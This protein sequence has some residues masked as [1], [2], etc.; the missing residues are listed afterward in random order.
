M[1]IKKKTTLLSPTYTHTHP[2]QTMGYLRQNLLDP[3]YAVSDADI[4]ADHPTWLYQDG[5]E[6]PTTSGVDWKVSNCCGTYEITFL[7]LMAAYLVI[8]Y[9]LWNSVIMKPMK[10]IAVF[11][12]G[13]SVMLCFLM[14]VHIT[15][16]FITCAFFTDVNSNIL[17]LYEKQKWVMPRHAG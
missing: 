1:D 11:V 7:S 15:L 16:F 3:Y 10:L 6:E 8:I 12:H 5:G 9:F 2:N 4:T 13:T 17:H 14:C